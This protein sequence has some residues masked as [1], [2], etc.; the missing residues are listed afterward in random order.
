MRVPKILHLL[1]VLPIMFILNVPFAH[2]DEV[3]GDGVTEGTEQCDDNN[4]I[5]GDGCSAICLIEFLPSGTE[6]KIMSVGG[7]SDRFGQSALITDGNYAIVG[8]VYADGLA[9]DSGMAYIF[10]NNGTAWVQQA[11]LMADDGADG[12]YFGVSVSISGDYAV[13]GAHYDA[14]NGAQSGSVYLYQRSGSTWTQIKKLTASDADVGDQFGYSV[15]INGNYIVVGAMLESV[16]TFEHQGAAYVFYKDTGGADN[17]GQQQKLIAS[18]RGVDDYFGTSV[19]INGDY[20]V[21]GASDDTVGATAGQGSAYVFH[22]SGTTWSQE[23]KI[24]AA[25]G[26]EQ[27]RFGESVSINGDHI[28]I[29]APNE[30]AGGD[31]AGAAYV[32]KRDGTDWDQETKIVTS[33]AAAYDYLGRGPGGVAINGDLAIVGAYWDDDMG[34][35]SGSAYLFKYTG[36]SWVQVEKITASDGAADDYFGNSVSLSS[37][38]IIVSADNDTNANGSSA[39]AAYI[40]D[41]TYCSNSIIDSG[42]TCDDGN[43]TPG[44][45]CSAT[46]QLEPFCGDGILVTGDGELCDDG[47]TANGDG[48]DSICQPETATGCNFTFDELLGTATDVFCANSCYGDY[49][50]PG[51][52]APDVNHCFCVDQTTTECDDICTALGGGKHPKTNPICLFTDGGG[53][54]G[55]GGGDPN[56]SEVCLNG[57]VNGGFA[58][59]AGADPDEMTVD[60]ILM[61]GLDT[62]TAVTTLTIQN[63]NPAGFNITVQLTGGDTGTTTNTLG[64]GSLNLKD[65]AGNIGFASIE[66]AELDNGVPEAYGIFTTDDQVYESGTGDDAQCLD[67]TV[68][69]T[70]TLSADE[71]GAPATYVGTAVYTLTAL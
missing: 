64:V 21:I 44:D 51:G 26:A 54:G 71:E 19:S 46:C 41:I 31:E 16:D 66:S 3:C 49:G 56:D 37:D 48:C 24:T 62:D 33:D 7:G 23:F 35:R 18:D 58:M 4:L 67:G 55:C 63:N 20:T 34:S 60:P 40:Y 52:Y 10:Y 25:D 47:N 61:S 32:F 15:S 14:D 13:V 27:D 42:E 9:T 2:A 70:Y 11:E 8:A 50:Y 29:G 22:R 17:W 45:G 59:D 12:D 68:V 28:I 43:L 5:D 30:D 38:H 39:G 65:E 36:T 6:T 57:I 1:W 69:V 53:G